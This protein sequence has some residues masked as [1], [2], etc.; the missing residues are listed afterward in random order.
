M[1]NAQQNPRD[2]DVAGLDALALVQA[3]RAQEW[4]FDFEQAAVAAGGP[5]PSRHFGPLA[6]QLHAV[7][8][9]L[10]RVI[11]SIGEDGAITQE[12]IV[13]TAALTGLAWAA[14]GLAGDRI[15][16]LEARV[17]ALEA[18]LDAFS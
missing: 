11:V 5:P 3:V 15:A 6:T 8:P 18:R 12:P 4:E 13:D 2:I 9:N 17:A 1:S 10:V 14:A 16:A 7:D